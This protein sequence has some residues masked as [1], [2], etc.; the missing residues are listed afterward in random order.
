MKSIYIIIPYIPDECNFSQNLLQIILKNVILEISSCNKFKIHGNTI[1]LLLEE[2]FV[3]GIRHSLLHQFDPIIFRYITD[4]YSDIDEWNHRLNTYIQR[5][6][7]SSG[8]DYLLV[9]SGHL[10]IFHHSLFSEEIVWESDINMGLSQSD[11]TEFVLFKRS[12]TP[13]FFRLSDSSIHTGEHNINLFHQY[14]K[15]INIIKSSNFLT[16]DKL[17][18][19]SLEIIKHASKIARNRYQKQFYDNIKG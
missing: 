19:H 9:I 12:Y 10:P 13:F 17:D 11:S 2:K 8:L 14:K 6:A 16:I 7:V 3:P 1:N 5:A 18:E 15:K 4:S